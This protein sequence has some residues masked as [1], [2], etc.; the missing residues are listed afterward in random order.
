MERGLARFRAWMEE[1]GKMNGPEARDS[2]F[3]GLK[4]SDEREGGTEMGTDNTTGVTPL[5]RYEG[6]GALAGWGPRKLFQAG[7]GELEFYHQNEDDRTATRHALGTIGYMLA[8]LAKAD[9]TVQEEKPGPRPAPE[10]DPLGAT[11]AYLDQMD[12]GWLTARE[13]GALDEVLE[14]L[15]SPRTMKARS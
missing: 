7:L 9:P 5:A 8:A 15:R 12:R 1:A 3:P 6:P 13:L 11:I 2:S 10:R 14:L 4:A